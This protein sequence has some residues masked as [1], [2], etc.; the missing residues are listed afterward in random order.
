MFDKMMNVPPKPLKVSP[1]Y[2][3]EVYIFTPYSENGYH[4]T[5]W[6]DTHV[7]RVLLGNGVVHLTYKNCYKWILFWKQ[8]TE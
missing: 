8:I 2:G 1:D 5:V 6:K 3:S 4:K 7:Q